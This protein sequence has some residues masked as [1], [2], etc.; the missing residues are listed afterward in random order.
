MCRKILWCVSWIWYLYLYVALENFAGSLTLEI[1]NVTLW[2]LWF[3]L[4]YGTFSCSHILVVFSSQ[5][6]AAIKQ[7][8]LT[9]LFRWSLSLFLLFCLFGFKLQRPF[10]PFE[11][12]EILVINKSWHGLLF[13]WK[14]W[15][16]WNW[17][18]RCIGMLLHSY[19]L[20]FLCFW[21][22]YIE[23]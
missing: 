5:N 1:Y 10:F 6:L 17:H 19:I 4:P 18:F 16:F 3:N 15:K 14:K 22:A 9:W 23:N 13:L 7:L 11:L 12:F 21:M 2:N 20:F 8:F